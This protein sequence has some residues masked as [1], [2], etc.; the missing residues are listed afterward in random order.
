MLQST[1]NEQH[2]P[3][4]DLDVAVTVAV[5]V[6]VSVAVA[7]AIAGSFSCAWK[8]A[9][10]FNAPTLDWW[11]ISSANATDWHLF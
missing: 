8:H 10:L 2:Q 4:A 5:D 11:V 6:D 3:D 1:P 7:V 9:A